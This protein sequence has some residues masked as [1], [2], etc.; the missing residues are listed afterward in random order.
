MTTNDSILLSRR[1]A[2]TAGGALLAAFLAG[3]SGRMA[4][5][6]GGGSVLTDSAT[7][8][9]SVRGV[10]AIELEHEIGDVVVRG[11]D[12][13]VV[14][15]DVV[16]RSTRGQA[17]LDEVAVVVTDDRGTL[18]VVTHDSR[19]ARV[20][21]IDAT[22]VDLTVT[23]PRGADAPA[24]SEVS[25]RVGDVDLRD[26]HGDVVV[27]ATVGNLT[28]ARVDGFCSLYTD[29]GN[30]EATDVAGVDTASADNGVIAV[31]VRD[32]RADTIIGSGLGDVDVWV[33][34]DLE[35]DVRAESD[36]RVRSSLAV[37]AST[38]SR[39]YLE[40]QLNG[41]GHRLHVFT[42]LGEVSLRALEP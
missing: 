25:T 38:E 27:A 34:P 32:V 5:F 24:V 28:V 6:V 8:T 16:K 11:G 14:R 39:R 35:I 19:P 3:C 7:S 40:G 21:E 15:L 2:L 20:A 1:R 9:H 26:T 41:G 12:V 4:G 31:E 36:V 22:V 42:G 23:V 29:I 13:D 30:I 17:G 18:R 33:A 37:D 10:D